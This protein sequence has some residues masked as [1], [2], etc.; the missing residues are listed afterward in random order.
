MINNTIDLTYDDSI[1]Q[2][3]VLLESGREKE[4]ELMHHVNEIMR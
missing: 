2:Q 3:I 4:K 1:I